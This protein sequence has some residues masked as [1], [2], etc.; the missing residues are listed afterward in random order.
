[1]Q[2]RVSAIGQALTAQ[3]RNQRRQF[4]FTVISADEPN[5]FAFP[6]G[7]V[8]I[9]EPLIELVDAE[10]DVL[11]FVLAHEI[12]HVVKKHAVERMMTGTVIGAAVRALPAARVAGNWIHSA[13]AKLL[14]SAYSQVHEFEADRFGDEL[15]TASGYASGAGVE[16]LGRL[17]QRHATDQT[18]SVPLAEYFA[19]HPPLSERIARLRRR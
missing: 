8:F 12:A 18:L 5:A 7:Y 17:A 3:L 1:M 6:G 4:R 13:A 11:A 19:A 10:T 16:L 14:T 2:A 9:T 15:S